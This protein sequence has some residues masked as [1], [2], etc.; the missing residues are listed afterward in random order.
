MGIIK[1]IKRNIAGVRDLYLRKRE[2]IKMLKPEMIW[3]EV[4][5]R[6]NSHCTHCAIWRRKSTDNH[7]TVYEIEQTLRDPLFRDLKW[8]I[9]SGG[10]PI[11]REDIEEI[12]ISQYK[13]FP[14][15]MVHLSTNGILAERVLQV[16]KRLLQKNIHVGIGVSLDAIGEKHDLIRGTPGNFQKTNWLLLELVKLRDQPYPL[17]ISIGFVLSKLTLESFDKV[18]DYAEKLKIPLTVQWFNESSFYGNIGSSLVNLSDVSQQ[19]EMRR[20]IKSLPYSILNEKWLDWLK[21]KSIRFPCLAMYKFI[22]LKCNGDIVPCLNVW[23]VK[24]GNVR[25]R[26]PSEIWVSEDAKKA[27][28]IVKD[29]QGCLNSWGFGYSR[30]ACGYPELFFKIRHP[31]LIIERI[32]RKLR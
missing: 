7:L 26:P 30:A 14:N 17:D 32:K 22:V 19:V 28:R 25:E 24:V 29:C 1:L 18:R 11:L 23:D 5:D 12:L 3:F 13:I 21:G 10:E 20:I 8:L 9:V 6:C 31:K 16:V 15:I 2:M 27:R 4:T